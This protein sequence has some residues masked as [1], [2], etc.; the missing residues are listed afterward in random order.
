MGSRQMRPSPHFRTAAPVG[1][2]RLSRNIG[3]FFRLVCRYNV[4]GTIFFV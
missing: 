1:N 4:N 2:E 3:G